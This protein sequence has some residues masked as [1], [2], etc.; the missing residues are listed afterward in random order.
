M[1]IRAR[2][3]SSR[4]ALPLA[5][6]TASTLVLFLFGCSP[7]TPVLNAAEEGDLKKV[8]LLLQQGRSIDERDPKVKFGWTPLMA[9]IYQGNTN[10][11][12]FLI[13]AGADLNITN[14]TG[15]TALTLSMVR[16]DEAFLLVDDLL[17]HGASV[18]P[19]VVSHAASLPPK[20]R[21]LEAVNK[22]AAQH[23]RSQ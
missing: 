20:P 7:R 2:V 1:K 3:M 23:Q 8:K 21:I 12:H 4:L 10:V 15:D 9:A 5:S 16:G 11:A 17:A 22:A 6:L 18:T 14:N 19:Q 13:A